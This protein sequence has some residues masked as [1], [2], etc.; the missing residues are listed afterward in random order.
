MTAREKARRWICSEILEITAGGLDLRHF[1]GNTVIPMLEEEE[2]AAFISRVGQHCQVI[3]D[4]TSAGTLDEITTQIEAAFTDDP[5]TRW[6]G[7]LAATG[8][9]LVL[10]AILA[11]IA[12]TQ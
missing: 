3:L 11:L 9:V 12:S 5:P 2:A 4:I 7:A 6:S 8:V 10:L 1:E